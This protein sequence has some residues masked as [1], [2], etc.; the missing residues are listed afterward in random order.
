MID[1]SRQ[2]YDD[3]IRVQ[4]VDPHNLDNIRGEMT[5][6]ILSNSSV[7]YGYYT[8][9]RVSAKLSTY[10]N[11]YIDNSWI[12]IIHKR[13]DVERELGTFVVQSRPSVESQYGHDIYT[14][15]LQSVLWTLS[16]DLCNGHF[17]IGA[18]AYSR[19]VFERICNTCGR[20][21]IHKAGERNHRYSATKVYDVGD[22]YLSFLF[23][24][25]DTAENRLDVDGHGR[26][27]DEPSFSPAEITPTWTIDEGDP[28]TLLLS[29]SITV[30]ATND[31][32]AGRAIVIYTNNDTE[33]V[34]TADR[35]SSSPYSSAQRGYMV[36]SKY[37]VSDM[38]P[39]TQARAQQL[40]KQYLD[41][42][43]ETI[44]LQCKT[45]YFPC[46]TGETM[47]LIRNNE[48]KKYLIQSI[49]LS[50]DTM[51]Q[52]LTLKEVS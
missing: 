12:R 41:E 39:A 38:S 26:I 18:G 52:S 15:D 30:S 45:L 22:D 13:G 44:Q 42:T 31:L 32:I 49:E 16:K 11:S 27:T 35:G 10:G 9:T 23:D 21:W 5:D 50:L 6:L 40:A 2:D 14:Y 46:E 25:C 24:V 3:E 4:L 28:R 37:Q 36:A 51:N 47:Y 8:D 29:D 43:A 17:S 7:S 48:Q 19:D 20:S 33:I 1:W 34:A